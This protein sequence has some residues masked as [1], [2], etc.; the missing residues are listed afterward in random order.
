MMGQKK[1]IFYVLANAMPPY[2]IKDWTT[3]FKNALGSIVQQQACSTMFFLHVLKEHNMKKWWK[4]LWL[5]HACFYWNP[6]QSAHVC[7]HSQ[8]CPWWDDVLFLWSLVRCGTEHWTRQL[9]KAAKGCCFVDAFFF[10]SESTIC[11][12]QKHESLHKKE[13]F[14]L[15]NNNCIKSVIGNKVFRKH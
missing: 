7:S 12:L 10:K 14:S 6:L 4:K 3:G 2:G 8:S 1:L 15:T 13:I 9:W 5:W 11:C